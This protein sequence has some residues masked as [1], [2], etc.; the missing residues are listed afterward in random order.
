MVSKITAVRAAKQGLYVERMREAFLELC[1]QALAAIAA[2]LDAGDAQMGYRVLDDIG[3]VGNKQNPLVNLNLS[4]A[5]FER[6]CDR[7][8]TGADELPGS[9][10]LWAAADGHGARR[11]IRIFRR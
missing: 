7:S 4:G 5:K 11:G 1:G 9:D 2:A 10:C 3:V 8:S 6:G